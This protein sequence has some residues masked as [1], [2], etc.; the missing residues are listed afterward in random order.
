MS[1]SRVAQ[2]PQLPVVTQTQYG[3]L[4]RACGTH[5]VLVGGRLWLCPRIRYIFV[6]NTHTSTTQQ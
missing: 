3:Y 4:T 2:F 6:S 5:T 1:G